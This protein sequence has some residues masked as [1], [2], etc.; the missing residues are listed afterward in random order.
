MIVGVLKEVGAGERRVALAPSHV[1]T[2]IGAGAEVLVE[3]GAGEEAG[4][5]DSAYEAGRAHVV[6]ARQEIVERAGVIPLVCGPRLEDAAGRLLVESLRPGAWL[7]GLLAPLEAPAT[8]RALAARGV[9]ALA[10]EL[11]PRIA[12]AQSMDAL[13]SMAT[14][15]GYRAALLAATTLPKMF[16]QLITAA[17]TVLAARVLVLGAGVAGLQAVATA[18][19]LGAVV[20]A[21]DLRPAAREEACSLGARTVEVALESTDVED[22]GGDALDLG[23]EFHRRQQEALARVTSESDVVIATASVPGGRAPVLIA[24]G[25]VARMAP[26][27]VIVDAAADRGGN[28][29]LTEPGATVVRHGVSI[30]GPL[31]LP[32]EVPR[33]ASQMYG[34][35]V[36]SFLLHLS[37]GGGKL[38]LDDEITR[39]TLV[40]RD[41]QIVHPQVQERLQ[42][43]AEEP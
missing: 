10:M 21:Y 23:S 1:P 25:T 29:E 37:K 22:A 14:V 30:L 43:G 17:G 24:A 40:A 42:A 4:F 36:V 7:L 27:S 39:A 31:N 28:C 11:M 19:R 26:G 32:A 38:D 12:R 41:G 2:L 15:S 16:P 18:H 34:R 9:V 3:S 8:M 20:R 6:A 33:D 5:P 13:S 35:N